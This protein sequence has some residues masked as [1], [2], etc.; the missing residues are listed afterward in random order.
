MLNIYLRTSTEYLDNAANAIYT[1]WCAGIAPSELAVD[2][3]FLT[4][5]SQI[6][7][8]HL[9]DG[10]RKRSLE[11]VAEV[12]HGRVPDKR[13]IQQTQQVLIKLMKHS[14]ILRRDRE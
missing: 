4:L 13:Y 8:P 12:A 9:S 11:R 14:K 2:V 7:E 3:D 10:I 6:A 1:A 5:C